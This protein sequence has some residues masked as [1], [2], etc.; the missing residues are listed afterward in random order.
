MSKLTSK[1]IAKFT[2]ELVEKWCLGQPRYINYETMRKDIR[3]ILR[4]FDEKARP[5]LS[6]DD[7]TLSTDDF[8]KVSHDVQAILV[9]LKSYFVGDGR[10][11]DM[12]VDEMDLDVQFEIEKFFE[13]RYN[14]EK[15][16]DWED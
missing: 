7:E 10:C 12:R 14:R 2:R 15:V 4:E 6:T 9:V 16:V 8:Y 11:L 3:A 1:S 5:V 13:R